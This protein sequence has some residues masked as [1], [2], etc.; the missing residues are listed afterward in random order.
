MIELKLVDEAS[1]GRV[2]EMEVAEADKSFVAPNIRS[3]A[4]AWL[5]RENGDVFPHAIYSSG[6]VIGF[7]LL[8]T[9]L[10]EGHYLIW[11]MMI[12]PEFQGLG[13]GRRVVEEVISKARQVEDI[14]AVRVDY[15]KGNQKMAQLL[16]SLGFQ[17]IVQDDREIWMTY[18]WSSKNF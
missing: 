12:A 15:V 8:E 7:L 1:F 17:Q 6:K 11:R 3:L 5:Y 4:E 9:D 13:Y 10:E 18:E 2:I 16:E 14:H